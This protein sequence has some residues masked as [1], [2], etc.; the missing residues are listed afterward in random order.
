MNNNFS[1]LMALLLLAS[2]VCAGDIVP[3]QSPEVV[4]AK[5]AAIR[6]ERVNVFDPTVPGEDWWPFRI[7]NK[8]HYPTRETVIRRE[9]LFA[10]GAKWDP[11]KVIQSERNLRANG[12][13][14]S[15]D[16]FQVKRPDGLV[17]A[18]VRSQDSWTTNPLFAVGTEGGESFF[19]AG[20]EEGNI[21]GYGKSIAVNFNRTGNKT[22]SALSYGDPRF[23][24]TRL[25]F[26]SGY[27]HGTTGDTSH[28]S[29][30]RPFY[31][32]DTYSASAV[33]W[34]RS[35]SELVIYRDAEELSKFRRHRQVAEASLGIRLK[36][37]DR[38]SVV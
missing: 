15:A 17:D 6:V 24:G 36:E 38:K 32:L 20:V 11:L 21:L 28:A 35:V 14:R 23:L 33:S 3:G 4:G 25:A 30:I 12:A 22:A 18:V 5:I 27:S 26:N 10:P 9:L 16:I 31:S 1:G 7:A 34:N 8:I 37:E 29:L 13:F 19:G 2:K